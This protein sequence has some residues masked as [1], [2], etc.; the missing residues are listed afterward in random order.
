MEEKGK[1]RIERDVLEKRK[2]QHELAK[3]TKL[4]DTELIQHQRKEM[5]HYS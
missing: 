3:R 1:G 5:I 2:T 4:N